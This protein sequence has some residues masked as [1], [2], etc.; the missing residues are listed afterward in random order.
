DRSPPARRPDPSAVPPVPRR[1]E[2]AQRCV[3]GGRL[4][5][6]RRHHRVRRHPPPGPA[7]DRRRPAGGLRQP[8]DPVLRR[9]RA[10]RPADR[11]GR[12]RA[13]RARRDDPARRKRPRP[14]ASHRAHPGRGGRGRWPLADLPLPVDPGGVSRLPRRARGAHR[15]TARAARSPV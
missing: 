15:R 12:G 11:S 3:R 7:V 10:L 6:R 5:R 2:P 14:R 8:P 13:A 1:V 9:D 4:R